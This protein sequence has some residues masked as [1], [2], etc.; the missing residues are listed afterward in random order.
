MTFT[1][2]ALCCVSS[3]CV[4]IDL[5]TTESAESWELVPHVTQISSTQTANTP[6]LVTSSTGGNETSA[7]GTVTNVGTLAIACHGGVAPG[8]LC[9]NNLYRIRWAKDC[10][11]IWDSETL[12]AIAD[13]SLGTDVFEAKIRIT[14][15]PDD[16]N[17][18]GNTALIQN[19]GFDVVEW[20]LLPAC[21][22]PQLG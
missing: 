4:L 18:A 14:S 8:R 1:A 12:T 19:Y 10:G 3:A 15:I 21:Q 6:K 11:D 2:G 7:C 13:G 9:I 20:I 22:S 17:I 16:F 5:Q